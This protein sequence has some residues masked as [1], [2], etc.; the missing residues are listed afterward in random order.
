[1]KKVTSI[2]IENA[3]IGNVVHI[4]LTVIY[5]YLKISHATLSWLFML[6]V[7]FSWMVIGFRFSSKGKVKK[8][9]VILIFALISLS[10]IIIFLI[11]GQ[12]LQGLSQLSGAQYYSL[13]Y[14]I[15]APIIAWNKPLAPFMH[16]FNDS[17]I[18][19]QMD[20]NIVLI[21]FVIFVGGFVGMQFKKAVLKK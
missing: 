3:V 18:Y 20:I 19:I 13:F 5:S 2:M 1:M 14:F 7:F 9:S 6:L 17:N 21:Y 16:L 15:G 11:S 4:V 12:L 8:E 10:P